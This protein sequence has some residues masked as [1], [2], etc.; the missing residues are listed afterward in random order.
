MYIIGKE[1]VDAVQRV[2]ESRQLFRYRG[3]EG[4]ESDSFEREWSEKIGA[5][6]TIA[7]TSGTAALICGLVG[8]GIGPGDEVIVPGYTYMATPLAPL[9]VGAVPVIAEVDA[10]LTID[11]KDIERKITP[12][13]KAIIPVHMV[14]LPS[15]MDAIM[16]IAAHHD[17][18]VLEDACQADGGAYGG[19]RLGAIGDAGAFSFNHFKIMTCGEGGALVTDDREVYER[20]LIF[21]DGGASFRDHASSLQTPF[22]AGWNFRINEILSAILRVQL[23]RLDGMLEAMLTE[24][25]LIIDA[26]NGAGPFTFNP[27]HD[28]EGDCGT[29]VALMFDSEAT[30]RRFLA[31]LDEAGVSADTPIDSGRHVYTNWEP[32]LNQHGAH[33]PAFDAYKLAP[34]PTTY[35]KD[36]C[37]RTLDVLSRTAYLHTNPTRDRKELDAMIAKVRGVLEAL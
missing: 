28:V 8:L 37:P 27:I 30:T 31:G 4:G 6:Y 36:M 13:T 16:D 20:A 25:R 26:L 17:L 9:A 1:E 23:T 14:G 12:R 11:P 32:V 15:N 35:S 19:K 3:G 18:K 24:K 5:K 22:F 29:T 10:S 21:H 7:L 33:N 34:E 2:I